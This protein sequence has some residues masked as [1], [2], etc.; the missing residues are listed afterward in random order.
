VQ[1]IVSCHRLR[2]VAGIDREPVEG[3]EQHILPLTGGMRQP[4]LRRAERSRL[5]G[6]PRGW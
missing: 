4:E 3:S 1:G 2:S 6:F 5:I